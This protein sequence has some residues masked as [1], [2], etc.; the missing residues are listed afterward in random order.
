MSLVLGG[1]SLRINIMKWL[2]Q[3]DISLIRSGQDLTLHQPWLFV[4]HEEK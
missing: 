1:C 3:I 4:R 2:R